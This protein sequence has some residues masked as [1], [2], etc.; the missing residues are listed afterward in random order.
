MTD[1]GNPGQKKTDL[2]SEGRSVFLHAQIVSGQNAADPSLNR[3][4]A[5]SAM[6]GGEFDLKR[7]GDPTVAASD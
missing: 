3:S 7:N 6:K 2:P 4:A 5:G 1:R